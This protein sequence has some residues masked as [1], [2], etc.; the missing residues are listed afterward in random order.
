MFPLDF[1]VEAKNEE[2]GRQEDSGHH[3]AQ[4]NGRRGV[5]VLVD[6]CGP[7]ERHAP[8]NHGR[9]ASQMYDESLVFHAAKLQFFKIVFPNWNISARFL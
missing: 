4:E 3:E 2:D 9:D 1:L 8:K 7:H 6:L 5:E